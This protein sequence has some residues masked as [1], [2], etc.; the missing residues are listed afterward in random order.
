[1]QNFKRDF[2]VKI[3]DRRCAKILVGETRQEIV[4]IISA[5]STS[6]E[7]SK[8]KRDVTILVGETRKM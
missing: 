7:R 2:V 1:M 3:E 4:L 6:L 8:N 5:I